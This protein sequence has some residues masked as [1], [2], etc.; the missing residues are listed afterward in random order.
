MLLLTGASGMLGPA[1]LAAFGPGRCLA[2]QHRAPTPAPMVAGDIT[3]HRLGLSRAEYNQLVDRIDGVVHAGAITSVAWS[4]EDL[5]LANVEGTRN[6]IGLATDAQVPLHHMSTFYVAGSDG[7]L[8]G[9]P[10]NAY[11]S[12]KREAEYLV[13]EAGIPTAVYRLPKL[14]GDTATG[15]TS[16]FRT[17]LYTAVK[18]IVTGNAHI[19]PAPKRSWVDFL[20][21]DHVAQCLR[22]AIDAQLTGTFWITAGRSAIPLESFVDACIDLA[23]TL[24]RDVVRP[25]IVDPEVVERLIMPAFGD[26]MPAQLMGQMRFGNNLAS[27]FALEKYLPD[28]RDDLPDGVSFP[29][30]PDLLESLRA[31]LGYWADNF[32]LREPVPVT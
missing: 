3:Q 2:L 7:K 8:S 28:S 27:G 9:A 17:G 29:P 6:I 12:T 10:A 18:T 5:A 4:A 32:V 22:S 24:G 13:A 14:I 16:T 30:I 20:P 11:Q 23:T 31:S 19:L 25:R 26:L 21:R 1:I 15:V